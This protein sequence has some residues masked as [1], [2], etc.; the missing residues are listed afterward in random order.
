MTNENP[1]QPDA[2]TNEQIRRRAFQLWEEAGCPE[3]VG[4]EFWLQAERELKSYI[5]SES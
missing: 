1:V 2:E 5:K 4:N 3:G